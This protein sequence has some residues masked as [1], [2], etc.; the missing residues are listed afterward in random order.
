MDLQ[1]RLLITALI[2]LLLAGIIG[3]WGKVR[4]N[5]TCLTLGIH[6]AY[7]ASFLGLISFFIGISA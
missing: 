7:A 3:Q 6:L 2:C 5:I 4:R 1:T